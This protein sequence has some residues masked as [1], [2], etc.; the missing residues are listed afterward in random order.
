M[1][2][3]ISSMTLGTYNLKYKDESGSL[4]QVAGTAP[5]LPITMSIKSQRYVDSATKVAGTRTVLRI[6][7][8]LLL[9]TGGVI[10]PL[11]AYLV[12]AV[13]DGSLITLNNVSNIVRDIVLLVGPAV[14][15]GDQLNLVQGIFGSGADR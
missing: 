12:V 11:S 15:A 3:N 4:R 8:S 6:D 14:A 13:P 1:N 5:S 7:Q 10:A 9:E 2:D